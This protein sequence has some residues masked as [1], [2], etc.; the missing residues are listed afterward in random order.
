MWDVIFSGD[1]VSGAAAG[2]RAGSQAGGWG[3]LVGGVLGGVAGAYGHSKKAD[4]TAQQK[5]SLDQ[6]KANMQA[7]TAANYQAHIDNLKKAQSYF[8]PAQQYWSRL[9]GTG[10]G[11]AQVG[12]ADWG[13]TGIG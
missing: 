8:G 2:A 10:T 7:M 4:A 5:N 6:I 3:A 11:P 9:Y 12:Q 13:N 1:T